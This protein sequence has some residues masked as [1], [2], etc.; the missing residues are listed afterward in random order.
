MNK[1]RLLGAVCICAI[2]FSANASMVTGDGV[3]DS[4]EFTYFPT[5]SAWDP[6]TNTARVGGF[7]APG[8]ATWSI[9][10]SGLSDVSG[11]DPDH[12][13]ATTS[14]I[15]SL[16]FSQAT[17]EAIVDTTI[18]IWAGVSGFTNLG[19]VA[20]GNVGFGAL[21][22]NGGHLC[23]IRIGAITFDGLFGVLAHAYQPGTQS[24]FG[25]G[26]TINGDMHIDSSKDWVS[27]FDL[28]TVVLHELGHSLGLGH[29]DDINAIMYP[30]YSG[31]NLTLGADDIAGIQSIYGAA[32]PVPAAAWLF[33]SGLLGLV[34][35]ARR[36]KSA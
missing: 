19:Q 9:M 14:A 12:G 17:I 22:A 25:T 35:I 23:D 28:A 34:G 3:P 1:S 31:T 5:P 8:G 11:F 30:L 20:D 33:G 16:G 24:I 2:S 10:G 18:D 6:G 26:G 4:S 27:T 21:E 32:V 15:T 36:K 7:P 29:S 13:V